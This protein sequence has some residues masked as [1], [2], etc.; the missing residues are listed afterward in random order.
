MGRNRRL[1]TGRF[2]ILTR[3]DIIKAANNYIGTKYV[4]KGMSPIFG[5]GCWGFF[6]RVCHD[7]GI[8][9]ATI[10]D[11]QYIHLQRT[12]LRALRNMDFKEI[13]LPLPGDV[14]VRINDKDFAGHT[15]IITESGI[16]HATLNGI[17]ETSI[18]GEHLI[19]SFPGVS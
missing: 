4:P 10:P 14:A 15:G 12:V 8:V 13:L 7:L 1:D 11:N 2:P 5:L 3:N 9:A 18:K 19:F 17:Q 16:I 6:S